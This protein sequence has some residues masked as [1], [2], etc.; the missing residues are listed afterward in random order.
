MN[1]PGNSVWTSLAKPDTPEYQTD[2]YGEELTGAESL[3]QTIMQSNVVPVHLGQDEK[4]DKTAD[5]VVEQAP[6]TIQ[7]G[8]RNHHEVDRPQSRPVRSMA[9]DPGKRRQPTTELRQN[10]SRR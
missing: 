4:A 8:T 5:A 6:E 3:A 1:Q 2:V 10:G 7:T 9:D